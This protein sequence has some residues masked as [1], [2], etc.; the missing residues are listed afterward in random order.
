MLWLWPLRVC[1]CR[2]P[3]RRLVLLFWLVGRCGTGQALRS[4]GLC[5][6]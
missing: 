4:A 3:A 1:G 2:E 5:V 6:A